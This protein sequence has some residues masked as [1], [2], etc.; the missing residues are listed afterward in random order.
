MWQLPSLDRIG[1]EQFADLFKSTPIA[2]LG[3]LVNATI[4]ALALYSVANTLV[5]AGWWTINLVMC[6]WTLWRW[7]QNRHR[8]ITR[9]SSRAISR[10]VM[11]GILYAL[12]WSM[13]VILYLGEIPHHEELLMGIAV[14]GMAAAGSIQLARIYPAALAYLATI[15]IPVIIKSIALGG[16]QYYLL[17]CLSVSYI[18][19]LISIVANSANAS[20]DR[21]AALND[22]VDKV[23]QLDQANNALEKF[24]TEDDLTGLVNRRVFHELLASS[25][26]EARSLGSNVSLLICDLDHFKNINDMSG[27]AVGDHLL[28]EIARR[29]E[30]SIEDCDFVAR[31]GGDEFAIVIKS[32]QMRVDTIEF[33][34]RLMDRVNHPV[35][36]EGTIINPGISIGV[37]IF[38][39]DAQ[40]PEDMLSHADMALQRGKTI[41][42]GRFWF[43]DDN[44]RSKL[45]SDATLEG[46][47]RIALAE[48]QFELFYQPKVDIKTGQLFGLESLLRWRRP[49]GEII[50]PGLFFPVAEERG[51]MPHISDF[52]VEQA[53]D[54]I[55]TW[56]DMGLDS[57][58]VS[59]NIH[60]T[61]IKDH[62]RMHL[63]AQDVAKS[64]LSPEKFVLEITEECVVGR[65]TD[66][67]PD[68]L[69]FLRQS[70]FRISLDDFGTGYASLAH[71]RTL[72]VDEIKLDRSFISNLNTNLTDRSIVQ[73]VIKLAVSLGLTIVAEGIEN[74][75][76]H[77]ILL[78]MGCSVG[79]GYLY[80]RPMDLEATTEYL[81]SA[82]KFNTTNSANVS[83]LIDIKPHDNPT[84][85]KMIKFAAK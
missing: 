15:F 33:I 71:L 26:S 79:Q 50:L 3:Q 2:T 21:S 16:L 40:R 77:N 54:D 12:P 82:A 20:I 10:A 63:L 60:P 25:I 85:N 29:L 52:V 80:G 38:P 44:L 47:L 36:L 68:T 24:A 32:Q 43:F 9:I 64:S 62:Y 6:T 57:G 1:P 30:D 74:Q 53:I 28:K 34:Q 84:R 65:G 45:S 42:R 61:Q 7:H 58:E 22:L 5:I 46:D 35:R 31:M 14:V 59:I 75:E 67:V 76:Q 27:H 83:R 18:V 56:Q 11:S 66:E 19:Y 55:C 81:R 49:N 8:V 70:N 69:E 73:A 37:S 39:N 13:L 72:P 78:A 23:T 17:A 51:L 48:E 4:V 41:S